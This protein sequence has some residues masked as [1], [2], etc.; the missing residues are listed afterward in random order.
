MVPSVS[1]CHIAPAE[2]VEKVTFLTWTDDNLLRRVCCPAQREDKPA[3][4]VVRRVP[5]P[6]RRH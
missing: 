1:T 3:K 4:Q 2:L 5:N 6:R